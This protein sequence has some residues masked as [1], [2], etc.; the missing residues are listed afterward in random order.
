LAK[1][2]FQ[3][4]RPLLK[5][6]V[7]CAILKIIIMEVQ[8]PVSDMKNMFELINKVV[9]EGYTH[10]FMVNDDELVCQD[11]RESFAPED[12]RIVNFYRFEGMS[13]PEDNSILYIME[14]NTGLKGTLV[15]AYGAYSDAGINE[16]I[17]K[18]EGVEKKNT[19]QN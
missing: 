6:M 17:K 7:F 15:D 13:D 5:G 2:A 11:K 14:T 16:F 8:H 10:N 1:K 9:K 19:T 3:R 12:V 18:V 4:Y